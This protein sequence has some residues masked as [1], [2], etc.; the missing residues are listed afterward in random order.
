MTIICFFML[1]YRFWEPCRSWESNKS[2]NHLELSKDFF[3]CSRS[4]DPMTPRAPD[5]HIF[6]PNICTWAGMKTIKR[7]KCER[8]EKERGILKMI[9]FVP[10][11][12]LLQFGGKISIYQRF[13]IVFVSRISSLFPPF[14]FQ[15]GKPGNAQFSERTQVSWLVKSRNDGV[16]VS[17][18]GFSLSFSEVSR[19]YCPI[20]LPE[21]LTRSLLPVSQAIFS[22]MWRT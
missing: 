9:V 19:L 1:Y 21:F 20:T 4:N 16:K 3:C 12:A 5:F 10:S 6:H 17:E 8:K 18:M 14:L 15:I 22:K 11:L 7:S 13:F 2:N